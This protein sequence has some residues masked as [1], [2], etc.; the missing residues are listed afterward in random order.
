VAIEDRAD[1]STAQDILER[2]VMQLRQK[3]ADDV[4][5]GG[6]V[7]GEALDPEAALVRRAAAETATGGRERFLK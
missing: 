3:I 6:F 4:R 5:L 7:D 1:D 2:F